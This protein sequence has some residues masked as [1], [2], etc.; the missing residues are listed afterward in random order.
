MGRKKLKPEEKKQTVSVRIP[1]ELISQLADIG[2]KSKFFEWLLTEHFN[3]LNNG[4]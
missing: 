4:K 3:T 1:N 2:N